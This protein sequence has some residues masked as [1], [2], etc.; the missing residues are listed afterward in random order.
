[1]IDRNKDDPSFQNCSWRQPWGHGR[2]D[3]CNNCDKTGPEIVE[4]NM[5]H[6]SVLQPK[7]MS[8][9]Y[10]L[11]VA[12]LL[13]KSI[14]ANI[15]S[16]YP[17]CV[18]SPSVLMS[19]HACC[20]GGFPHF[21]SEL[22]TPAAAAQLIQPSV[23]T[24]RGDETYCTLC[25]VSQR[26]AQSLSNG[27]TWSLASPYIRVHSLAR[28]VYFLWPTGDAHSLRAGK[29]VSSAHRASHCRYWG[30]SRSC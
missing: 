25:W 30:A 11:I 4:R 26:Y 16:T 22:L 17:H 19:S 10:R 9:I 6:R 18:E 5:R 24:N 7:F 20:E 13:P 8:L 23:D 29:R 12:A 14:L 21:A 15:W 1:M 27:S 28:S 3:P 2:F